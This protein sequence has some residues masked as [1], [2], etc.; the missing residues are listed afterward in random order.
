MLYLFIYCTFMVAALIPILKVCA[1]P[2]PCSG[3]RD[4]RSVCVFLKFTLLLS[5]N[6]LEISISWS[7]CYHN[8]SD[9]TNLHGMDI[10]LKFHILFFYNG[11]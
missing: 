8:I 6:Q 7:S 5:A 2:Y 10:K 11:T 4:F 1:D 9:T 3:S